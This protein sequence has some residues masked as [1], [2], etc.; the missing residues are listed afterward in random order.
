MCHYDV[1]IQKLSKNWPHLLSGWFLTKL[2]TKIWYVFMDCVTT[3][4]QIKIGMIF[5]SLTLKNARKLGKLATF[6]LVVREPEK[7]YG[8]WLKKLVRNSEIFPRK[9][10]YFL[11]VHEPR[12]NLSSGPRDGKGWE[13][14]IYGD[15]SWIYYSKSNKQNTKTRLVIQ[16]I[17]CQSQYS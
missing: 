12:Q 11:V 17:L 9:C 7:I 4:L 16:N 14:L 10:R 8:K 2:W 5:L 3:R 13:P 6:F 1:K 15:R